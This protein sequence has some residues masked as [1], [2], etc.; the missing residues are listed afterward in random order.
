MKCLRQWKLRWWINPSYGLWKRIAQVVLGLVVMLLCGSAFESQL[1]EA[2]T[3]QGWAGSLRLHNAEVTLTVVPEI[4]RL[5]QFSLT[6]HPNIIWQDPYFLG[7]SADRRQAT[8]DYWNNFGGSKLWVAPQSRWQGWP[9]DFHLDVA[10]C[11][12]VIESPTRIW[13]QGQPS[14]AAGVSL[15]RRIQLV[16]HG[17][18]LEYIMTNT[19]SD[20][21]SWGVW[22]VLQVIPGGEVILPASDH[23]QFWMSP[24]PS[25][26]QATLPEDFNYEKID[27]LYWLDHSNSEVESK[28]FSLPDQGWLAYW[29]G[30][31][32]FFLF[33]RA[34][35]DAIY[36]EGEGSTEIYTSQRYIE[37]E[38]VSPLFTLEP[39]AS[40]STSEFWRMIPAPQITDPHLQSEWI[41]TTVS[42]YQRFHNPAFK[43]SPTMDHSDLRRDTK[44]E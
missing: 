13:L 39:G 14:R 40:A 44:P 42:Y 16:T 9:P 11:H 8:E 18:N 15:D 41:K 6:D 25:D 34:D 24:S 26:P 2:L 30:E 38:H 5:M 22:M 32:V 36:P 10:P 19:S 1:I 21:V 35:Q 28:L 23:A 20:R 31:Q 29:V 27:D 3:Y 43:P 7:K 12:A 4:A 37:L 33:Y 17:I